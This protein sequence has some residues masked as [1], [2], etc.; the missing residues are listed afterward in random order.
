MDNSQAIDAEYTSADDLLS[1]IAGSSPDADTLSDPEG[2]H[3]AE[4][5]SQDEGMQAGEA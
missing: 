5:A 1:E 2:Q 4:P 3:E